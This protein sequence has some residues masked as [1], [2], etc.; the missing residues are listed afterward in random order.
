MKKYN[1]LVKIDTIQ[2]CYTCGNVHK[3]GHE[4]QP[5]HPT[6]GKPYIFTEAQARQY[7]E[8]HDTGN[9]RLKIQAI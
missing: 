1:V 4:W 2:K 3:C 5:V 8:S 6:N 7:L 9:D